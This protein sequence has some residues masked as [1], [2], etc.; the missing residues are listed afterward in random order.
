MIA[1]T[2]ATGNTGRPAAEALLT[3]SE[4]VRVIGRDLKKLNAFVEKGAEPFVGNVEDAASMKKAF[5]GATAAYLVIPAAMHRED[6][7]GYQEK[8]TDAYA[9]AIAE[10][11]VPHAITLSSIGAQHADKTGPIAGLHNMEQKLN[12]ISGLNVLHLRP[13]QF[14]ENLFLS[15]TPLRTMGILPGSSPGDVPQP[16]IAAKD[17]GAYA[18]ERLGACDFSGNSTQELLGPRDFTMKEVAT[19]VGKAIGKPSLGYMQVPFMMLEPALVEIGLPRSTA[20]MIIE[21]WKAMNAGLLAPQ[22]PRS[23]KNTTNTMLESFVNEVLAP[24][25]L[26]KTA[27]A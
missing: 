14:M 19:I 22:E 15:L 7:R 17:I 3:R 2:G 5:E 25:F 6:F 27:S 1:I 13:T 24:A 21:M 4:Q 26:S 16:W 9:A 18:A 20:R 10:A 8:V 23:A 11:R 12:R